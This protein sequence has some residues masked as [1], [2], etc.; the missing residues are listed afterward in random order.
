MTKWKQH[1]YHTLFTMQAHHSWSRLRECML[2]ACEALG[3]PVVKTDSYDSWC[4]CWSTNY[5]T[6]AAMLAHV[7]K[8]VLDATVERLHE[9]AMRPYADALAR[10]DIL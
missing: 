9:E 5:A 3:L 4:D 6:S 2:S 1:G 7:G 10:G 8:D